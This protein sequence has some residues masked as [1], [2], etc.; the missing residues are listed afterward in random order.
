[1][2]TDAETVKDFNY[3]HIRD[4]SMLRHSNTVFWQFEEVHFAYP[5]CVDRQCMV[6]L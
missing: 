6:K 4:R 5:H 1:M 3:L 2:C